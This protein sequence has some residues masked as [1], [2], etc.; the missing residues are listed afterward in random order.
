M[1][2]L[3]LVLAAALSGGCGFKGPLYLPKPKPEAP[4]PPAAI[5][6]QPDPDRPVPAE[7]TVVPQ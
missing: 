5:K 2:L 3:P 4:K 6:P 1:R 7:S